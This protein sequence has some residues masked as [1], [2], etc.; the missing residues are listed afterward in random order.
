VPDDK[1][2]PKIL[3]LGQPCYPH[4]AR[5]PTV[6]FDQASHP[7]TSLVYYRAPD[8][9]LDD[10]ARGLDKSTPNIMKMLSGVPSDHMNFIMTAGG[11]KYSVCGLEYSAY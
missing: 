5:V 7:L 10:A 3:A 1:P 8:A 2:P 9:A 11:M 4:I 6:P